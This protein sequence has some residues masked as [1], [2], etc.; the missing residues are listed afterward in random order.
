MYRGLAGFG[1]VRMRTEVPILRALPH[2]QPEAREQAPQAKPRNAQEFRGSLPVPL[3]MT[4]T[5][6]HH[7]AFQLSDHLIQRRHRWERERPAPVG[8][9]GLRSVQ[10]GAVYSLAS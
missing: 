3:C 9:T 8:G 6:Q 4:Q 1:V 5:F 7:V 2:L 10:L